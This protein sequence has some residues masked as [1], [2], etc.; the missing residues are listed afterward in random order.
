MPE[1][2]EVVR[3]T[4]HLA[5]MVAEMREAGKVSPE[6]ATRFFDDLRRIIR[7]VGL[8]RRYVEVSADHSAALGA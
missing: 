4:S 1:C 2:G 5:Q 7:G 3:V 6:T 8:Y